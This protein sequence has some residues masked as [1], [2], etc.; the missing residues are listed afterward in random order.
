MK[1]QYCKKPIK[2]CLRQDRIWVAECDC[3]KTKSILFDDLVE[4]H[5][6][7]AR[8]SCGLKISD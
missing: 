5:E 6:S 8:R 2:I 7:D 4:K 1:C 3:C